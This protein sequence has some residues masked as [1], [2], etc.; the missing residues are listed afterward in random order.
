MATHT[1][2][3][4]TMPEAHYELKDIDEKVESKPIEL[5]QQTQVDD[6]QLLSHYADLP[7]GTMIRKFHRLFLIGIAVASAGM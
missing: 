6:S 2:Q 3:H 1:N 5:E 4:S 7:R